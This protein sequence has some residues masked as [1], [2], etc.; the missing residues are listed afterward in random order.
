MKV[1]RIKVDKKEK[2]IRKLIN[3]IIKGKKSFTEL[4]PDN[5]NSVVQEM[6]IKLFK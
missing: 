5:Q 2:N 1:K 3:K 6:L 4:T